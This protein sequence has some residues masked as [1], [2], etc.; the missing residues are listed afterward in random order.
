[1]MEVFVEQPLA[2]PGSAKY[3]ESRGC[4]MGLCRVGPCYDSKLNKEQHKSIGLSQ[5][6]VP[7][8]NSIIHFHKIDLN[9][10]WDATH[11]NI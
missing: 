9:A 10:D 7:A 1:M 5:M 3:I 11:M 4:A 6:K 2:S 8:H